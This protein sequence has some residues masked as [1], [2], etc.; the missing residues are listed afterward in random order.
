MSSSHPYRAF[1]G[2][3]VMAVAAVSAFLVAGCSGKQD[4]DS[5]SVAAKVN[6]DVIVQGQVEFALAQQRGLRADQV[7]SAGRQ[8]LDRMVELQLAAQKAGELKLDALPGVQMALEMTRRE[9]LAKAYADRLGEAVPKPTAEEIEKAYNE[10]PLLFRERRIY[11]L[12]ELSIEAKPEQVAE[13]RQQLGAVQN[14]SDFVEQLKRAGYRFTANQVVRTP[15]QLPAATLAQ[16][17]RLRD[18]Q[19][20]LVQVPTGA[21]VVLLAGSSAQP[22][23]LDQARP[24]LELL[25]LQERR[26]KAVSDDIKAMRAAAKIEFQGKFAPA[27]AASSP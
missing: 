16:A 4:G 2:R 21:N 22:V 1:T 13:L 25:L 8:V 11:N 12:Q 10:R 14:L 26:Q 17:A 19:A 9:I 6:G 15:E 27:K 5:G 3:T 23:S 7:E 24:A 20:F 18:G